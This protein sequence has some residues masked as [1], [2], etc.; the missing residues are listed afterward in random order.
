[1]P[2]LAEPGDRTCRPEQV[3]ERRQVVRAHVE[4]R[5]GARHVEAL[6][7]RMPPLGSEAQH[8]AV[9]GDRFA[10]Q[11]AV[12]RGTCRLQ[13]RAEERVGRATETETLLTGELHQRRDPRRNR[14][15]TASR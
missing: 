14:C 5:P 11:P 4:Q 7:I 13:T 10:D 6:R 8:E 15:P 9:R 3:N 2:I 1:M 12:D